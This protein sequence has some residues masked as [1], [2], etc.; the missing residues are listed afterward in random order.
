MPGT[1]VI[2]ADDL[3]L[4]KEVLWPHVTFWSKQVEVIESVVRD[5]VTIVPSC[6]EAGKD[7]V[8]GFIVPAC[9]TLCAALDIQ[10]KIVTSSATKEHLDNLWGEI[11]L[12][13]RTSRLPLTLD[14]GGQQYLKRPLVYQPLGQQ[15]G[16]YGESQQDG[17]LEH[18][19]NSYV[20]SR[21]ITNT[22]KG[23][24]LTGHHAAWTLWVADECSGMATLAFEKAESWAD[25]MLLIGNPYPCDSSHFF[26]RMIEAC[27]VLAGG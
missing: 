4:L 20:V 15:I 2:T 19:T 18:E 10:C 23:E 27:D 21:V 6:H 5:S 12:F 24:G 16:R 26:R 25:H 9:F 17:T 1:K 14:R 13:M 7:F 11:D 8:A 22:H 3:F